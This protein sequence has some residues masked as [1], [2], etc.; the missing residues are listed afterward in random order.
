MSYAIV[1]LMQDW[2]RS[3]TYY[4]YCALLLLFSFFLL[5]FFL[6][7]IFHFFFFFFSMFL[8]EREF[9]E[10]T[11]RRDF[12]IR[13]IKWISLLFSSFF[14]FF[15]DSFTKILREER[16]RNNDCEKETDLCPILVWDFFFFFSRGRALRIN[17]HGKRK[18]I[19]HLSVGSWTKRLR[20]NNRFK[21]MERCPIF[22]SRLI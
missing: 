9:L 13:L 5:F 7:F 15:N 16:L 2:V 22:R 3:Q 4:M 1:K 19:F 12:S 14:Y 8:G 20:I 21:E 6:F 17:N 11:R 10:R 18:P